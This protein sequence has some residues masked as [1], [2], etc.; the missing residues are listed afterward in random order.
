MKKIKKLTAFILAAVM[1]FAVMSVSSFAWDEEIN[2]SECFGLYTDISGD[3]YLVQHY[4]FNF[5]EGKQFKFH[6]VDANGKRTLLKELTQD[7]TTLLDN[8]N[9]MRVEKG[10]FV[11]GGKYILEIVGD[12]RATETDAVYN[13]KNEYEFTYN[14]LKGKPLHAIKTD[15]CIT[16]GESIDLSRYTLV[17]VG[18]NGGITY[19]AWNDSGYFEDSYVIHFEDFAK[20]E[21]SVVTALSHGAVYVDMYDDNEQFGCGY[22]IEI[23]DKEPETVFELIEDSIK[24]LGEGWFNA[25][26]ESGTTFL[27]LVSLILLPVLLPFQIVFS[28]L[29]QYP[30]FF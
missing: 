14:D 26:I 20:V 11:E 5:N 22:Y 7:E 19:E 16:E 25:S 29:F 24:K 12:G 30:F 6:R 9:P 2:Y 4:Y 27:G 23:L 1:A 8:G 3:Y 17:P 13:I 15:F 10:M 28:V 18:Y 21:G